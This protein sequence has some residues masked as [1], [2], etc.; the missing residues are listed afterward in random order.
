[1]STAGRPIAW[2]TGGSRGIGADTAIRLAESGYDVAITARDEA[3]LAAV[4][5]AVE[6]RGQRCLAIASDLTD[7]TSVTAFAEA[8]EGW[9]GR[10]DVLFNNGYYQGSGA[11]QLLVDMPIEELAISLEADVV[12]SAL[13]CQRAIR[14]M[15]Q[16]ETDGVII[17]MSS[18]VVFLDPQHTVE[19][20]GWS[21]AYAAGKAG[22]DQ[23]AK[24]INAECGSAGIRA[25]TVEP[26]FVAYGDDFQRAVERGVETRVNPSEAISAALLWLIQSPEATRLLSKRIHLPSITQKYGLLA[27][28][29][30]SGTAFSTRW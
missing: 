10:C 3:R 8:A 27:G 9:G 12:A 17:N 11:Q 6:R 16:H 24:L 14:M 13:L 30:G 23:F 21:V 5:R 19:H 28:W 20:G 2:V 1:V 4:A 25:Y 29:A 15:L 7:R 26:G 18:A 22:I